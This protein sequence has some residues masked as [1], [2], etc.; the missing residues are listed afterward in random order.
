METARIL[1]Q[2]LIELRDYHL[3]MKLPM[4]AS[5]SFKDSEMTVLEKHLIF[6]HLIKDGYAIHSESNSEEYMITYMGVAFIRDGGYRQKFKADR[7]SSNLGKLQF[8]S[9]VVVS[10]VASLYYAYEIVKIVYSLIFA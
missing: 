7:T 9:I 10:I 1:D 8:W 5:D 3:S 6:Q 2:A 4:P